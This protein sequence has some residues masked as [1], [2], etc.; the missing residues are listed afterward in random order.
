MNKMVKCVAAL[1][2]VSKFVYAPLKRAVKLRTV[3]KISCPTVSVH[4]ADKIEIPPALFQCEYM[5]IRILS[6]FF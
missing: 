5:H 2:P 3:A 4:T 6:L 1:F